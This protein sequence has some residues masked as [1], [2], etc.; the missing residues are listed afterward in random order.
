MHYAAPAKLQ[1]LPHRTFTVSD[2]KVTAQGLDTQS[3]T[4]ELHMA[5]QEKNRTIA[6][7][8]H[9]YI[10][11]YSNIHRETFFCTHIY[12]TVPQR[13]SLTAPP[14]SGVY[15]QEFSEEPGLPTF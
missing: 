9:I 2:M 15:K 7:S 4:C 10:Y 11:I 5:R 6:T 13:M 14:F 12:N 3:C 8:I 1:L